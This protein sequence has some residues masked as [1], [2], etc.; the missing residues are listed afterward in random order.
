MKKIICILMSIVTALTLCSG[1]AAA[2]T[3]YNAT[4]TMKAQVGSSSYDSGSTITVKPGDQVK[5]TMHLKNNYY[6]GPTC[7]QLFYTSSFFSGASN[8]EFNK[9]GKFYNLCGSSFCTFVDWENVHVNNRNQGWPNYS[10]DKLAQFKSDHQ[11]LRVVMTTNTGRTTT[12]VKNLDEDLITITFNVSKSAAPGSTGE[13][14]LPVECQ[15]TSSNKGG[16]FY[17]AIYQ[18]SDMLGDMLMY[19]DD[20]IFDCSKAVLKFKVASENSL[21]D[22]NTDGKIN[23]NDA[24]VVLQYSVGSVNL[25]SEQKKLADV[26]KDNKINSNDALKILQYSVG[27]I[28]K[29]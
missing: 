16:Y 14:I 6:I 24:L 8:G 2:K 15:R 5:V 17:S 12:T 3:T 23:S 11:F 4:W 9:N 13:I 18:T 10:A 26:N 21:G 1:L 25:S 22:V 20:Q 19:S 29:F 7:F 27:S 28:S